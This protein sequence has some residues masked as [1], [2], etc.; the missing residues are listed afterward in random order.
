MV[1]NA[2]TDAIRGL[3]TSLVKEAADCDLSSVAASL[4]CSFTEPAV[5][6]LCSAI[7]WAND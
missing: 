3:R 6:A 7:G 2:E 5:G 1:N 4:Q